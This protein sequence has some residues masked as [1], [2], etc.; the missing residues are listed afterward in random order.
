MS[1]GVRSY[2]TGWLLQ[3]SKMTLWYTD[4]MGLVQSEEFD[5]LTQPHLLLLVVS[6]L[7]SADLTKLGLCPI[8]TYGN[9]DNSFTDYNGA[10][11]NLRNARDIENQELPPLEFDI[12]SGSQIQTDLG[13]VGR[14]TTIF[15]VQAKGKA[16]DLFGSGRLMAKIAWPSSA[17]DPEDGFIR[18]IRG[19]LKKKKPEYLKHIVDLKCSLTLTMNEIDL[20]RA[21]MTDLPELPN[22]ERR[23]FRC[24]VMQEY[25][26]LELIESV[27]EFK[28]VFVDTVRG[29]SALSAVVE[30]L[31]MPVDIAHHWVY[32][33]SGI[34][35]HDISIGNLMFRREGRSVC[36]VLCDWDLAY[37]PESP[38][39]MPRKLVRRRSSGDEK[40]DGS[41]VDCKKSKAKE[42]SAPEDQE[43]II[44]QA[45]VK[46]A[47]D[48]RAGDKHIGPCYRTGT[49]PFMA[50]DLLVDGYDPPLL[51]RH[52]LESFF[53]ILVWTCAVYDP[54]KQRFGHIKNWE[55]D[56]L[57]TIGCH[58]RAFI[59]GRTLKKIF[60]F[61]K[62]E[63]TPL[64]KS[65]VP[66]LKDMFNDVN[67]VDWILLEKK[68]SL[69]DLAEEE[70]DEIRCKKLQREIQE[71]EERRNTCITYE[72]FMECLGIDVS[73]EE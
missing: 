68:G 7:A 47:D 73:A 39:R 17:R 27:D 49:G 45:D 12:D 63:Y 66:Y 52:D 46:K 41:K 64:T 57:N 48:E 26:P 62:P 69:L 44:E 21:L 70:G 2:S 36:G 23:E 50:L 43:V 33:T 16:L 28:I 9:T 37:N 18:A 72:K 25:I 38:E 15:A 5:I 32:M 14:G 13:A 55:G 60:N 11:L 8:M 67:A 22:F 10:T 1:H 20:P 71:I 31:L 6:A 4:R 65:W 42:D 29:E 53:F 58:K 3:E 61:T 40:Q 59:E 19:N 24:L 34:L 54:Q 51:Y 56:D 30:F 35:H